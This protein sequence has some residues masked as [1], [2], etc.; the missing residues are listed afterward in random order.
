MTSTV[1]AGARAG[2]VEGQAMI[3]VRRYDLDVDTAQLA[4]LLEL[5]SPDER[6]RAARL[7]FARDAGR[8]VAGRGMLRRTLAELLDCDPLHL[9]FGYGSAGKPFLPDHPQLRF[10]AAG[11]GGV[12]VVATAVGMELGIDTELPQ[13]GFPHLDVARQFFCEAE[14]AQLAGLAPPAREAAFRRCWT[15]KEAYVKALG[16][17]LQL[18]LDSFAVSLLPDEPAELRSPAPAPEREL[19]WTL[20]DC[21]RLAGGVTV[22]LCHEARADVQVRRADV[23]S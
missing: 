19:P 18:P 2:K 22:A 6:A 14:V 3:E 4:R 5:L 1:S 8:F 17:G 10:N 9:R 21:S 12:G 23:G 13:P 15:R 11:S 7:R 16:C 20:A